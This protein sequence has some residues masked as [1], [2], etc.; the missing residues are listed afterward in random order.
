MKTLNLASYGVEEMNEVE[1]SEVNGGIAP[2]VIVAVVAV[3]AALSSCVEIHVN[4]DNGNNNNVAV[5]DST[6]QK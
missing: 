4:S 2:L 3:A 1:M 5:G 6:K